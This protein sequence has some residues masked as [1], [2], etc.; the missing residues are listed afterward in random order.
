MTGG[1][2]DARFE[3]SVGRWLRAYPRRWRTARA[4]EVTAVLAD[5]AEP[6][7]HRLDLRS[8]LGL[9][10]A[11]WATRWREHPPLLPW[12]GYRLLDR[13]LPVRYRPWV[14]DDI[15]GALLM[16]RTQW[17]FAGY[18]LFAATRDDGRWG[19]LLML[20]A[21]AFVVS[22]LMDGSRR[23]S[24]SVKHM[25]LR[26]GEEP[27]PLS[28]VPGWVYRARLRAVDA[29]PVVTVVLVAGALAGLGAAAFAPRRVVVSGCDGDPGCISV[30]GG[31]VGVRL[32]LAVGVLLL[33]VGVALVPLVRRRLARRLP[34]ADQP[35]RWLVR[36][37]WRHRVG[38]AA[39][40]A[41]AGGWAAAEASGRLVLL[42]TPAT[43]V[44][45]LLSP[46]AVAACR[47]LRARPD[48]TGVAA[49]DV[50][51]VALT[52][53]APRVDTWAPGYVPAAVPQVEAV[54]GAA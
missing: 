31:P 3:R 22:V 27:D 12:L 33:L 14:R 44:C 4:A 24:A 51:R 2:A 18:L 53:R 11:G 39:V 49:V 36:V 23:R 45:C 6:G 29:M 54:G 13:R 46:G 1:G 42:S 41:S 25:T 30:D 19:F 17:P 20:V 47:L 40:V 34:G 43:L 32:E 50:R 26:P 21:I 52:G 10:R 35:C 38:A 28:I 37:T 16:L 7:A 8:G 9:V 5:L 15:A 48:L